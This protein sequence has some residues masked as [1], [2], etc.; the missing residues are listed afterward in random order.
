MTLRNARTGASLA[1]DVELAM[2]RADR[3]R[4]LLGRDHLEPSRALVLAPCFA[5][6]TAFMRF[7]ID[8]VFVDRDGCTVRVVRELPPW[9][10][11]VAPGAAS[12]VELAA[13]GLNGH[14]I[15]P[16]DQIFLVDP[17][18]RPHFITAFRE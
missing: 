18:D 7:P 9:R 14:D 4:A 12:V 16:G 13:G 10:I 17:T 6:H 3:R 5:I 1:T 11:A 8:V 15:R 2:T